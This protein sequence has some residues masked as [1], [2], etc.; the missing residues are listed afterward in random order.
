M[1][2][3]GFCSVSVPKSQAPRAPEKAVAARTAGGK[4]NDLVGWQ[5]EVQGGADGG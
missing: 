4:R 1:G 3:S 5:G 2:G